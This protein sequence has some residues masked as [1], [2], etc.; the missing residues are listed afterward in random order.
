MT[1][2]RAVLF[3]AV[4]FFGIGLSHNAL[5]QSGQPEEKTERLKVP[6]GVGSATV[7]TVHAKIVGV[8]QTNKLITLE[9]PKGGE[10]YRQ[11]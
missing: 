8:D 7:L 10:D 6:E 1:S 2:P 9:G 5:A 11:G 3:I 4:V